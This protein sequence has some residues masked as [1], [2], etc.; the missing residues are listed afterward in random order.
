MFLDRGMFDYYMVVLMKK[1]ELFSHL[2]GMVIM[3]W[4]QLFHAGTCFSEI[5][6][7]LMTLL[8]GLIMY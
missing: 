1:K 2:G 6:E 4:S 3:T 5:L 7:I 8:L